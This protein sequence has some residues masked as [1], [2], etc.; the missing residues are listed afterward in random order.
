MEPQLIDDDDDENSERGSIHRSGY[1]GEGVDRT[2]SMGIPAE[3]GV[4]CSLP[5][6]PPLKTGP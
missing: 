1:P 3:A 5:L 6:P 4:R 2:G